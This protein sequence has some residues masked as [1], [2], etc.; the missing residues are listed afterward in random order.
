MFFHLLYI[1]LFRYFLR[2]DP[3]RSSLP[4]NVSPRR[5]CT[6]AA[7]MISR[8]SRLYAKSYGT[9]QICNIVVYILHSACTIHLLNLPDKNAKRDILSGVRHLEEM[10]LSWPVAR[11]T[12]GVLALQAKRWEI[13]VPEEAG[14]VLDRFERQPT[15]SPD[16]DAQTMRARPPVMRP[17][18]GAAAVPEGINN[19]DT[20][21]FEDA[22]GQGG[23]QTP[24]TPPS[25]QALQP[26]QTSAMM[27][28]ATASL[29]SALG[30][31]HGGMQPPPNSNLVV[32]SLYPQAHTNTDASSLA[33]LEVSA[34]AWIPQGTAHTNYMTGMDGSTLPPAVDRNAY[35]TKA[36]HQQLKELLEL[37]RHRQALE[38]RRSNLPTQ[39]PPQLQRS[40]TSNSSHSVSP[41]T[42]RTPSSNPNA[43]AGFSSNHSQLQDVG[44][45]QHPLM[46][47]TSSL[48]LDIAQSE[49]M[50][51]SRQPA[52]G[53]DMFG[54][55]QALLREGQEWWVNDQ[56]QVAYGFGRWNTGDMNC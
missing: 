26:A 47:Q 46:H 37:Q 27:S 7:G 2:Y 19:V 31:V 18:T 40:Y 30:E 22:I 9:R 24:M 23:L 33:D 6:Q 21:N 48:P 12:L 11:R 51:S 43:V 42:S 28:H 5:N 39:T 45:V 17:H 41:T 20:W 35:A 36:H 32:D 16:P 14:L 10:S 50:P 15:S 25:G 13:D 54:G 56:S 38:Q 34:S 49:P 44:Y 55:V 52:P 3:S 1:H 29:N 4:S 53:S 8:L